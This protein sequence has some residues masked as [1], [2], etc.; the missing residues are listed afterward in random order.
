[1]VQCL[2]PVKKRRPSSTS[3]HVSQMPPANT[4]LPQI[5]I[6]R[7]VPTRDII[8]KNICHIISDQRVVIES[9]DEIGLVRKN[10]TRLKWVRHVWCGKIWFVGSKFWK[11]NRNFRQKPKFWTKI[12]SLDKNRNFGQKSKF[13][14][15]NWK[16]GQKSKFSTKTEILKKNRN[17]RLKLKVWTKIEILDKNWNFEQRSKFSTKN[18]NFGQKSKFWTKIKIMNKDRNFGQKSKLWTKIEIFD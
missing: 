6:R 13:S 15:K 14:T 12:E 16:F 9:L 17:F 2:D 7:L 3:Q 4:S 1:L 11:T 10:T 5:N 8:N 18:W